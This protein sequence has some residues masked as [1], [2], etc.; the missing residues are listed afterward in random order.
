MAS[1]PLLKQDKTSKRKKVKVLYDYNFEKAKEYARINEGIWEMEEPPVAIIVY[2]KGTVVELGCDWPTI[3]W[4]GDH[5]VAL[6][7][8]KACIERFEID[9]KEGE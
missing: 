1:L 5:K 3:H 4:E 6:E 9:D 7:V 2:A 8:H